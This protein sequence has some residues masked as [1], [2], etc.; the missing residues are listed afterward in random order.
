[1]ATLTI[2]MPDD[3]H[4]RLKQLARTRKV[5]VNKLMEEFSIVALSEFDAETRFRARAARGNIAAALK[6]LD[7]LD[8]AAA[9]NTR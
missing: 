8:R 4:T 5:S 7:K 6:L 2:R 9:R 3:T 1:M